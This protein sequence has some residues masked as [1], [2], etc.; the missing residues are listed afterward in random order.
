MTPMLIAAPDCAVGV[1]ADM[2]G[3]TAVDEMEES[4]FA[5]A[6][7]DDCADKDD[8]TW[9]PTESQNCMVKAVTSVL[10]PR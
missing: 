2:V 8:V 6:E 9:T 3:L 7:G 1:A 4:L 10:L 5:V